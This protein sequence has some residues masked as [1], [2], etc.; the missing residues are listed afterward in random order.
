MSTYRAPRK[1]YRAPRASV[2]GKGA[3]KKNQPGFFHVNSGTQCSVYPKGTKK[4]LVPDEGRI[5]QPSAKDAGGADTR[6][7]AR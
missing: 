6:L 3:K 2:L 1:P 4:G 5:P 7:P